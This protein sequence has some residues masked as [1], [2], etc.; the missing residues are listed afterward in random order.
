MQK[1]WVT[2]LKPCFVK[3][4]ARLK[5]TNVCCKH[6]HLLL[7]WVHSVVGV[8]SVSDT[9]SIPAVQLSPRSWNSI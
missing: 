1:V 6:F 9:V 3:I 2:S 8:E 7:L 5:P 4:T